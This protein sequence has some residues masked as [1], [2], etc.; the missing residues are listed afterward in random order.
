[1]PVAVAL[2]AC[3]AAAD[4]DGELFVVHAVK[5]QSPSSPEVAE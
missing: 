4:E 1:M 5:S 3:A 2:A